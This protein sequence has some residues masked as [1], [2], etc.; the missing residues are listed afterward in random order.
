MERS[1]VQSCLAALV[2]LTVRVLSSL[3]P[4]A[5]GRKETPSGFYLPPRTGSCAH[6]EVARLSLPD[7]GGSTKC[8]FWESWCLAPRCRAVSPTTRRCSSERQ[9]HNSKR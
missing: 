1:T 7:L 9:I 2:L 8:V 3:T 6:A 5:S 4:P